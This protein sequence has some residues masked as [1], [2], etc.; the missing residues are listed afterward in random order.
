MEK[1]NISTS[2]DIEKHHSLREMA[3]SRGVFLQTLNAKILEWAGDQDVQDLIRLGVRL[4]VF[5]DE[6][7]SRDSTP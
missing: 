4:P 3:D 5:A 2:I 7:G 6:I 1:V